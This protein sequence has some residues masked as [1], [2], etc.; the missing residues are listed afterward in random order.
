MKQS[1]TMKSIQS[2][3]THHY[4]EIKRLRNSNE[5]FKNENIRLLLIECDQFKRELLKHG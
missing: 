5:E 3:L 2:L 4:C 1:E